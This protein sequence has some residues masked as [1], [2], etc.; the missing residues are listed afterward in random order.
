MSAIGRIFLVLNLILSALFVGWAAKII[1]AENSYRTQYETKVSEAEAA[2][3]AANQ[4]IDELSAQ[5]STQ[6]ALQADVAGERDDLEREV[7]NLKSDLETE[8]LRVAELESND[9]TM[10]NAL[11]GFSTRIES[12]D[13]AKDAAVAEARDAM[14]ERDAA[15]AARMQA[16]TQ[17]KKAEDM[18]DQANLQIADLEKDLTASEKMVSRQSAQLATIVDEYQIDLDKLMSQEYVEG[19]V[20]SVKNADGISLVALNVGSE[21]K[22]MR[23]MTFQIWHQGRYKGEV[24]VE[25]VSPK[26]CSALVTMLADDSVPMAEGDN[27]ATRL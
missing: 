7:A 12:M 23:G 10:T 5:L 2:D 25:S 24:R 22:V 9:K 16:D 3:M 14:A 1:N 18:L 13:S 6:K 4:R 11:S 26:M 21:D 8:R 20:L 17:R 19:N 27:A 15:V